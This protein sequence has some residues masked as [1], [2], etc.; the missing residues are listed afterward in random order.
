MKERRGILKVE[1]RFHIASAS[2]P[3]FKLLNDGLTRNI[4]VEYPW[5]ET[6]KSMPIA[7]GYLPQLALW[8]P[9]LEHAEQTGLPRPRPPMALA[10]SIR[11]GWQSARGIRLLWECP[12]IRGP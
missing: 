11:G 10:V 1:I 5:Q 9:S 4:D 6:Y 8:R 7:A 3:L 2:C 12:K